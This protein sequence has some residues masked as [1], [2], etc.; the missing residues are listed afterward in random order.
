VKPFLQFFLEYRHNDAFGMPK[1]SPF[2]NKKGGSD[3]VKPVT[4]KNITTKGPYEQNVQVGQKFVGADKL[5]EKLLELFQSMESL[6]NFEH[7][8]I[9]KIKNS[10][11]GLQLI[12]IN[13]MPSGIVIKLK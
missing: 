2:E 10:D 13:N 6:N 9:L 11:L 7:G 5:G 1:L 12:L 8:K 3:A 4:R